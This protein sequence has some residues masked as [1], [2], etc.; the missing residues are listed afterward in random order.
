[1]TRKNKAFKHGSNWL[2]ASIVGIQFP[3]AMAIGYFW[4]KWMDGL[5]GTDPWLTIIFSIFGHHRR[6]CESVPDH[7]VHRP[8]RRAAGRGIPGLGWRRRRRL[9]TGPVSPLETS[10]DWPGFLYS[11]AQL[12]ELVIFLSISGALCLT[13][14]GTVAII[15][16]RWLEMVIERVVQPEQTE[17]RLLVHSPNHR[18]LRAARR[19][20]R[21]S[22]LVAANRP[23]GDSPRVFGPGGRPHCRGGSPESSWRRL[24]WNTPFRSSTTQSIRF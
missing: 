4:G 1:M 9:N 3:V 22:R 17:L 18:A 24:S 20:T 14:A 23:G 10:I 8:R 16:F 13:A 2:N 7:H 11:Q 6:F 5:F 15:N 12:S 19:C 21:G